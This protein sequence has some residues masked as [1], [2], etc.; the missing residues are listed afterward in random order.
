MKRKIAIIFVTFIF[1]SLF[2]C[3]KNKNESYVKYDYFNLTLNDQIKETTKPEI[4]NYAVDLINT[5][6]INI[7]INKNFKL[8][9]DYVPKDLVVLDVKTIRDGMQL[10]KE[11]AE[12]LN[13]MFAAALLD[14]VSL[15]VGSAYRSYSKQVSIYHNCLISAGELE[16]NRSCAIAGHSEHQTGLAVDLTNTAKACYLKQCFG[17]TAAGI[18]LKENAY[19]YGFILRYTTENEGITGYKNEPWHYRYIGIMEAE[20]VYNSGLCLEEF[21][22]IVK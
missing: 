5:D 22:G 13:E 4:N 1:L 21:Y 2:A 9:K 7:L 16:A 17:E 10:R 12:A 14:N 3:Q 8:L 19:K 20:K 11:A 15:M 18:W 6:S